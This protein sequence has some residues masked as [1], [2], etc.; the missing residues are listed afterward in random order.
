MF[1]FPLDT[2]AV[3]QYK[4]CKLKY[5]VALETVESLSLIIRYNSRESF[6][7]VVVFVWFGLC[8]CCCFIFQT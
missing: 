5:P 4:C 2:I 1:F 7:F 3:Y 6:V 8:F